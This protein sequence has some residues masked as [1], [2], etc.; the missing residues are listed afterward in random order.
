[1]YQLADRIK[2]LELEYYKEKL[3]EYE[4]SKNEPRAN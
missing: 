1:M 3:E 2:E 4:K